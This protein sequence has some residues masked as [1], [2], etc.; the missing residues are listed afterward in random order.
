MLIRD[1]IEEYL[2]AKQNSLASSTYDWYSH[3][4]S[5]F[6]IWC[7]ASQPRIMRLDE[8]TPGVVQAFVSASLSTNSHT[9]HARAQIIKGFLSWC[10][11]DDELGV[12]RKTVERI[13]LPRIV[14]SDVNLFTPSDIRRLLAACAGTVYP[15]RNRAIVHV[16]LDTGIRAAELAYDSDRPSDQTGLRMDN[17][18]LGRSDSYIWVMGKGSKPRTIGLGNET[19]NSIRR[20][21]NRERNKL[22]RGGSSGFAFLSRIGDPLSVRMLQQFLAETGELAGVSD[23]HPHRFRHTF[24]VNQLLAGTPDLVL[25]RLLGHTSLEAT[26]IYTRAMTDQQ[27]RLSA[28]SVMDMMKEKR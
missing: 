17:V 22:I 8:I 4:L 15:H 7:E 18:V 6:S 3:F 24:A 14:Q 23:T 13:E 25:M 28:V 21:F 1:A 19:T 11:L 2:G 26:K 16:L 27:A 20:Y 9:R 5:Q 10:S 12:R